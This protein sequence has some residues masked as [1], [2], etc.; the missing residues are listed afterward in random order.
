MTIWILTLLVLGCLAGIGYQQGAIRVA[1]SFIG[2]IV[3]ALLA[4]PLA[5]LV[6]PAV[7]AMKVTN[8]VLVWVLPP[9]I[10]FVIVLSLFKVGA[11][12]LH[13]KVDH[14]YRYKAGDLPASEQA[15]RETLALPIYPELTEEMQSTVVDA[16]AAAV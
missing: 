6:K 15:A 16:I 13:R 10:V 3:A 8:P 7:I 9:F 2:I 5:K 12:S 11:F 4:G 1:I 14:F